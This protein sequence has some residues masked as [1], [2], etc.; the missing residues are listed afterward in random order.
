MVTTTKTQAPQA[1]GDEIVHRTVWQAFWFR[2]RRN[3]R[4]MLALIFII[5]EIL[6]AIFAPWVAPY[7][8]DK[9]DY[10]AL[11]SPP[12]WEHPMG[13]DDLGRD[14]LSRLIYGGRISIAVGILAQLT[15][16]LIGLPIG[17]IAGLVGRWVDYAF[18]RLIDI[19][20]SIP[21][22]LL[23]LLM[24]LVLPRG[25]ISIIIALSVT[26]WIGVA[27]L[28]R[29]QVLSLKA[30]DYVRAARG[31]GANTRHII[32]HHLVRNTLSPV[33]VSIT[34]GVPASMMAEAGLSFLGLGI[35]PPMSS[36]GQMIGLYQ[37]YIQTSWHLT[38]FPALVLS[39]TMLAWFTLGDGLRDAFDPSIQV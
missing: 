28:V 13:T 29:G 33:L 12:T 18:M 17:A 15:Q 39:V 34:L 35:T 8:P 5:L 14:V 21:N 2:L 6:V 1:S 19:L 3:R 4:A 7:E 30:T 10:N 24:V 16:V 37:A 22:M 11:W 31:M 26:G 9:S 20:S 38:V 25:F 32:T 23:Y 27:R 36:W